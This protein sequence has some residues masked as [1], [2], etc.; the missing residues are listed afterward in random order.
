MFACLSSRHTRA[1]RGNT[2]R[3][4]TP[5]ATPS[6]GLRRFRTSRWKDRPTCGHGSMRG[7]D[8][9]SSGP[10][11]NP[12]GDPTGNRARRTLGMGLRGPFGPRTMARET[13]IYTGVRIDEHQEQTTAARQYAAQ[14]R[15]NTA[16]QC[17]GLCRPSG[18]SPGY[19]R[20]GSSRSRCLEHAGRA[21]C[22]GDEC[23]LRHGCSVER[24]CSRLRPG[25]LDSREGGAKH[26]SRTRSRQR[27][28]QG[29]SFPSAA[30]AT[31]GFEGP[32]RG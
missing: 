22:R 12:D 2:L 4:G 25:L 23:E 1:G 16:K 20:A 5:A 19:E 7:L 18:D 32:R 9:L 8:W 29:S 14:Q 26:A 11:R 17:L 15:R 3:D 30:L 13:R 27:M 21:E 28:G 31:R 24:E 10:T 6:G